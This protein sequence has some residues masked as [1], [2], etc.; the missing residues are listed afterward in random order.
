MDLGITKLLD[1][2]LVLDTFHFASQGKKVKMT[3]KKKKKIFLWLSSKG[4][5]L[6]YEIGVVLVLI[7]FA[8]KR[9]SKS[10]ELLIIGIQ[11]LNI[12]WCWVILG[13]CF[14]GV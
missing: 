3:E 9:I 8:T 2:E 12:L 5:F 6:E 4:I 13:F 1:S 14:L 11:E 10:S 7:L